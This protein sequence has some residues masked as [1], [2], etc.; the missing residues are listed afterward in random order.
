MWA[1]RTDYRDAKEVIQHLLVVNDC[2][3]RAV[4]LATDFNLALTNDE[5]QRQLL[6]QVIEYHRKLV[7]T[8]ASKRIITS[9]T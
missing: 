5:E 1:K 9:L 7:P 3:E 2:A 4:K 8:T 6:F